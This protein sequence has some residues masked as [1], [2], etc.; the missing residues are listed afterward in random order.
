MKIIVVQG[1]ACLG[2][3]SLCMELENDLPKCKWF[4]LDAYKENMW[5]KFGFDSVKQRDHQS[6][7]ARQLFYSDVND[8]IRDNSYAYILLDYAFTH[9]YWSEL[10][11]S[12]KD[13]KVLGNTLYLIPADLTK[14]KVVWEERSR[15]FTKRHAGHGATQYHDG[16]GT[17]YVNNYDS[18]V[19]S[20]M[21][22][23]GATLEVIVDFQPY[24]MSRTYE[25]I[26][27]FITST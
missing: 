4:S 5:D 18:K 26:K 16:I 25:D 14:H 11:A 23:V 22:T 17:N 21:P 3:S 12:I 6:D 8:I 2:K 1:M 9:K 27:E 20:D 24:R 10:L 19:F 7:L 13:I 15:D